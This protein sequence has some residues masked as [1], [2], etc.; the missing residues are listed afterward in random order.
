M[1]VLYNTLRTNATIVLKV[2][3]ISIRT[4]VILDMQVVASSADIAA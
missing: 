4:E 3:Q 1:W 2:K